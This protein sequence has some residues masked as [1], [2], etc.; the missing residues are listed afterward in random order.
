MMLALWLFEDE[1]IHIVSI[2]FTALIFNELIMVALEINT[3]HP[4]MIYAE[5][6]TVFFY[7]LSMVL[8]KTEF[9]KAT[10]S[11]FECLH[12]FF[13]PIVH[14]NMAI[15]VENCRYHPI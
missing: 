5:V 10:L 8:L 9:G 2:T 1:F 11:V 12:L 6:V 14:L 15:C 3:W 13:R 7:L 4:F